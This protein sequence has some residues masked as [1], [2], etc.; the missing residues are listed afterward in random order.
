MQGVMQR[1]SAG[2]RRRHRTGRTW[3]LTSPAR[4][5]M[6]LLRRHVICVPNVSDHRSA[7]PAPGP[8]GC[9]LRP[10]EDRHVGLPGAEIQTGLCARS[11]KA[12]VGVFVCYV[13]V[14]KRRMTSFREA[15]TG[16][17]IPRRPS[18]FRRRSEAGLQRRQMP[19]Q[20]WL[21]MRP[22]PANKFMSRQDTGR[23]A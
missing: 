6:V 4:Q 22:Y 11:C 8:R 13:Q 14:I 5:L 17:P 20:G 16:I 9:Q 2:T 1:Q 10:V 23:R 18:S 19:R 21:R 3:H 7:N 15:D 12:S